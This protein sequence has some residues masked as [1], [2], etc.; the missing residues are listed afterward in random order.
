MGFQPAARTYHES[1]RPIKATTLHEQRVEDL[2]T[3]VRI[4]E[5]KSNTKIGID[6]S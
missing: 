6:L 1:Q 5:K 3:P 2:I 4:N